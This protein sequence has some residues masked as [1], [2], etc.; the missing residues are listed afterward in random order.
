MKQGKKETR[1][2]RTNKKRAPRVRIASLKEFRL[3]PG[4]ANLHTERGQALVRESLTKRKFARPMFAAGDKTMLAGNLT[5]VTA[6]EVGMNEAIVIETDGTRPIIHVR[7]DLKADDLE[8]RQLALED[9]RA[10]ELSLNWDTERLLEMGMQSRELLTGWND[11]EWDALVG[12]MPEHI[13]FKEYDESLAQSA[14]Q[15][16]KKITCPNCG[17]EIQI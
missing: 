3:D 8:A 4:N 13:A 11:A 9:N 6:E 5:K 16:V 10:A 2:R 15:H 12:Q 17:H 14:Q 1:A 7:M